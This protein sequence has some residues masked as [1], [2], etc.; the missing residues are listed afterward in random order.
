MLWPSV[1]SPPSSFLT[2]ESRGAL[3]LQ[4][5]EIGGQQLQNLKARGYLCF[6]FFIFWSSVVWK[7]KFS[8]LLLC[9]HVCCGGERFCGF[10]SL[11]NSHQ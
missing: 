3:K 10:F 5:F 11:L 7:L 9:V 4:I 6:M 1:L 2:K 8:Y